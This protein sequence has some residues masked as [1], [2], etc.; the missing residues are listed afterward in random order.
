MH[1]QRIEIKLML[2]TLLNGMKSSLHYDQPTIEKFAC[3][4]EVDREIFEILFETGSPGLPQRVSEKMII[5][6]SRS[7]FGFWGLNFREKP[8]LELTA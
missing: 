7:G 6:R 8:N 1:L 5:K 3:G 2:R 4:D